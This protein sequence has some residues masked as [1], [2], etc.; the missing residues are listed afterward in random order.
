MTQKAEFL[1]PVGGDRQTPD[2]DRDT[3]SEQISR[4]NQTPEQFRQIDTFMKRR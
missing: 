2:T 1:A 4:L 3:I